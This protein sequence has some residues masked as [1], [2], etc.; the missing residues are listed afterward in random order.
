MYQELLKQKDEQLDSTRDTLRRERLTSS[1][2]LADQVAR[3]EQETQ[4]LWA[5]KNTRAVA[6]LEKAWVARLAAAEARGARTPRVSVYVGVYPFVFVCLCVS[7]GAST[8][9]LTRAWRL[10]VLA[11]HAHSLTRSLTR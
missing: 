9:L 5:D 7:Q 3:I 8:L 6:D 11:A 2:A 10:W 4:A 1:A